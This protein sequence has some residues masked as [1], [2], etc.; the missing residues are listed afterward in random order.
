MKPTSITIYRE[1]AYTEQEAVCITSSLFYK[2]ARSTH[3]LPFA[4]IVKYQ[5]GEFNIQPETYLWGTI[6]LTTLAECN[7]IMDSPTKIWIANRV[8]D[9]RSSAPP[10]EEVRELLKGIDPLYYDPAEGVV[11]TQRTLSSLMFNIGPNLPE[12]IPQYVLDYFKSSS[13]D[14]YHN[15]EKEVRIA[16]IKK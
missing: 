8:L 9:T 10:K 13:S 16:F 14:S 6:P 11:P 2:A 4:I 3:K 1:N 15:I 7:M 12:I 5:N